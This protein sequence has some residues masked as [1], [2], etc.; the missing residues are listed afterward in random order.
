MICVATK[1]HVLNRGTAS[2]DFL[3]QLIAWGKI[4]SD[5]IFSPNSA[6]D[7]Y[8]SVYNVLGPW[9]E[10]PHRRCVMLEV[11]RVLAGFES[12]WNWLEGV[13]KTNQTTNLPPTMQAH[14]RHATPNPL[15]SGQDLK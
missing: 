6:S 9:Q 14:A 4:A 11:M 10:A 13:D 5:D 15:E 3:S 12:S 2:D 7:V 8:S 1:Q